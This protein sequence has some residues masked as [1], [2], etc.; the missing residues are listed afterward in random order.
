M[1]FDC[2]TIQTNIVAIQRFYLTHIYS[3]QNGKSVPFKKNKRQTLT[4]VICFYFAL[5]HVTTS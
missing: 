4:Y 5:L 1:T 3:S 2:A